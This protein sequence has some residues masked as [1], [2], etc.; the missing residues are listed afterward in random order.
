M[1]PGICFGDLK[2]GWGRALRLGRPMNDLALDP[3]ADAD[4]EESFY[5]P[6]APRALVVAGEEEQRGDI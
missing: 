2:C 1:S 6:N 4:C 3:S 5:R